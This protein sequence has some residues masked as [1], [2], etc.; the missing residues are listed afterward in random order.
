VNKIAWTDITWNPVWGCKANCEYCYARGIAKRFGGIVAT[1]NNVYRDRVEDFT[2]T[3]LPENFN[4]FNPPKI[5]K[6]IFIGS[7]SDIAFWQDEWIEAVAGKIKQYPQHT[8]QLLTKFPKVYQKLDKIMPENVWFGVTITNKG[9]LNKLKW[10]YR[11][12]SF[13]DRVIYVSFEPLMS[14]IPDV[15]PFN[16]FGDKNDIQYQTMIAKYS[17]IEL[18]SWIIIGTMSGHKRMPAKIEWV[19]NLVRMA[20]EYNV[21]VFV[22]QLE[23]NGKVEKDINKFPKHLQVRQFPNRT[24]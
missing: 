21:P 8:F 5:P 3:W 14:E 17:G 10:I 2:P 24:I 22:K 12:A 11:Y 23:I 1:K 6:R 18:L 9:E 16:G 4:K 15:F 20:R 7:M 13:G 19:R